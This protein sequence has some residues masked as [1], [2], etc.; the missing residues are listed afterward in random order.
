MVAFANVIV[1]NYQYL[2]DPKVSEVVSEKLEKQCI[3]VFDEAHNIDNIAI[4][5]LSVNI[6]QQTLHMASQNINQ[7]YK[8]SIL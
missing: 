4:E 8:V 5:A 3:V 1:F 7:L 6:R 2:I